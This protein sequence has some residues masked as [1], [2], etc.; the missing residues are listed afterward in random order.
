MTSTVT[1]L[2]SMNTDRDFIY[3]RSADEKG[4]VLDT[5]EIKNILDGVPLDNPDVVQW[6]K[7]YI[8]ENTALL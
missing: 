4:F 5:R 2:I 8:D 1:V 3:R 7:E 6:M